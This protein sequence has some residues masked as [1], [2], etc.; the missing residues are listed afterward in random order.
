MNKFQERAANTISLPELKQ[1]DPNNMPKEGDIDDI[2]T[3]SEGLVLNT[4]S[5][6][7]TFYLGDEFTYDGLRVYEVTDSGNV[8][9]DLEDCA[10]FEPNM[11]KVG[12][13][14]VRV[15]YNDK[16]ATYAIVVK[17]PVFKQAE[18]FAKSY[19]SYRSESQQSISFTLR[20]MRKKTSGQAWHPFFGPASVADVIIDSPDDTYI[21]NV[22]V[23]NNRPKY[24]KLA[25]ST[26]ER[27]Y[28]AGKTTYHWGVLNTIDLSS[29]TSQITTSLGSIK[30]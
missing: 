17:L 11:T 18:T 26:Y 10:I 14:E 19:I 22:S 13:Q 29:S 7:K 1:N 3:E 27:Q 20:E 4:A 28:P 6:K 24:P 9:V 16:Y 5:V 25:L 15:A 2:E 8:R 12:A 30:S 23:I 21:D